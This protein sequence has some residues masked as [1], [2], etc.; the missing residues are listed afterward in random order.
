MMLAVTAR[1]AAAAGVLALGGPAAKV[2][3]TAA[4]HTPKISVHW[5]Y[6]VSVSRAGA[7]VAATVTA[8]IVDPIGGVHPVERGNS[9]KNIVNWPFKGTFSDFIIWP[10]SSAIGLPLTFRVTVHSGGVTKV[11]RYVVTPHK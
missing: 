7:P 5:N 2:T 11:I 6:A 10:A 4:G 9:T 1:L 3:L 8:Q